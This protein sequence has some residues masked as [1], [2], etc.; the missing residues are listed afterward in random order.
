MNLVTAAR[1]DSVSN[2]CATSIGTALVIRQMK[3]QHHLFTVR[4][5]NFTS[6]GPK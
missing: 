2:D 5:R 3:R 6:M 4:R 1:N